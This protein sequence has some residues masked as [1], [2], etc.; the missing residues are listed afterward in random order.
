[1]ATPPL[2]LKPNE[3]ETVEFTNSPAVEQKAYRERGKRVVSTSNGFT[4]LPFC[5]MKYGRR[6]SFMCIR[7]A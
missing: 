6:R 1:M 5:S 2:I 7:M 4:K 3:D